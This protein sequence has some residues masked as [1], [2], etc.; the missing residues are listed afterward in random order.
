LEIVR[1][2]LAAGVKLIELREKK[3][4]LRQLLLLADK[5][6][7]MTRRVG[8]LLIINDHLDIAMAVG[9][10]GVHVGQDDLPVAIARKIAPDM[11]IGASSHSLKEALDAQKAGA[12]YVNIGPL[13]P[14]K[15]KKWKKRF[16]GIKKMKQISAKLKIPFTVMGGIKAEHIPD[17]IKAGAK[18]IAVVTAVTSASDPRKATEQ[19]LKLIHIDKA[20][21]HEKNRFY[22]C[23]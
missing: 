4:P 6:R 17:L 19:L 21:R 22:H 1:A 5:V 16:L 2:A 18:M 13:F 23:E 8:A 10:D 15:T 9:A 11:I 7:K 3:M 20:M 12:S 14:T